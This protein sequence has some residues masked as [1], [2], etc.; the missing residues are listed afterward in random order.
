MLKS[1]LK[2][3]DLKEEFPL[4]EKPCSDETHCH[5]L[6]VTQE[7]HHIIAERNRKRNYTRCEKQEKR[8]NANE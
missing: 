2:N 8:I 4:K 3:W 7:E 5:R 6:K 1:G